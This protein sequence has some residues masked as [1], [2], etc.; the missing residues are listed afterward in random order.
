M[1]GNIFADNHKLFDIFMLF[2]GGD[3]REF[4]I[5]FYA[6]EKIIVHCF[7]DTV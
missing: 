3:T 7:A 5:E 1:V 4:M 2:A 6:G